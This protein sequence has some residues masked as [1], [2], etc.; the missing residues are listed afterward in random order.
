VRVAFLR[1]MDDN[2]AGIV[3]SG[4]NFAPPETRLPGSRPGGFE[5]R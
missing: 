4:D 2:A 3:F 1:G 5:F